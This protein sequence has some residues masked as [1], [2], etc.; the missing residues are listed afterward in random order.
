MNGTADSVIASTS[1]PNYTQIDE[2]TSW[3]YEAVGV[4]VGMMGARSP[5]R[6]LFR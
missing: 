1:A 3:F 2:C 4:S 6:C 5:L